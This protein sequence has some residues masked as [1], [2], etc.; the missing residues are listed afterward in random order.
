MPLALA[1]T[2]LAVLLAYLLGVVGLGVYLSRKTRNTEAFT[3]A[4]RNLPGWALGLSMFGSYISSIS[5]ISNPAKSYAQNWNAFA[6]N[7]ATPIAAVVAVFWF[8]PFYRRLGQISAYEHLETRFGPWARTYA[9][10]CF[11]LTQVARY[12]TICYLLAVAVAP[13]LGWPKW[14]I[15][16]LTGALITTYTVLGGIKAAVWV[17]VVQSVILILGPTIC[18][19][20]LLLKIPGGFAH[21]VSAGADK[22][23]FSLGD[24][25]LLSLGQATFWVVFVRGLAENLSNFSVDQSFVQRYITA[26]SQRDA[27][28]SVWITVSLYV[29][30][31]AVFFFIGTALWVFYASS[32]PG[33]TQMDDILPHFVATQ[34]PI[35]LAGLVVAAAFAAGMDSNLSSMATLTLTD[36]YK[37]Y[38]RPH[39]SERESMSVLHGSTL[40]WGAA[41]TIAALGMLE[42]KHA[43]DVW[44]K[45][46]GIFSGGVLGLFLLGML[47]KRAHNRTAMIA[48]AYGVIA[49]I[50]M[51]AFPTPF[52]PF[53]IGPLG[54]VII[55]V[56]G[57]ILAR[58]IPDPAPEPPKPPPHPHGFEVVEGVNPK[59][60]L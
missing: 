38:L 6:F 13:L 52:H 7:L 12:A 49:I 25:T 24:M 50:Y 5:F 36:V 11:L 27:Q 18:V 46:A 43:L 48:T 31:A 53:L 21:V 1:R 51:T 34:L 56:T 20:A 33:L 39:A 29:P 58:L 59:T 28:R 14:V 32:P 60:E 54:T 26:R 10:V 40:L 2:D 57:V 16:F 19:V 9:V 23:R 47:V 15:I 41:G 55:L 44:W 35:G 42:V 30:V 45:W 17:G 4:D 8:V 3:A 22:N 37:R